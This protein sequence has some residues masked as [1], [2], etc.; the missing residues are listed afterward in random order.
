MKKFFL[1]LFFFKIVDVKGQQYNRFVMIADSLMKL[2]Q[3]SQAAENYVKAFHSNGGKASP[4]DRYN[5]AVTFGHLKN[6]DTVIF[7][8]NRL[9]T[10]I[11]FYD[12]ERLENENAFLFLKKNPAW[13]AV[14]ERVRKNGAKL[15]RPLMKELEEIHDEDQRARKNGYSNETKNVD[16]INLT[17]ITAIIDKYGWLGKDIVGEKGNSALFLVIQHSNV[18]T[19]E[20]YLPLVREAVKNGNAQ[21]TQLALMEDR[22]LMWRGKKQIYGS[23]VRGITRENGDSNWYVHPIEN[24]RE[25]DQR[26]AAIGLPPIAEYV[27]SFGVV[28]DL[29]AHI[30]QQEE[31]KD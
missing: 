14:C 11:N 9:A 24:P 18:E 17:K 22:A 5:A 20:K 29:E 19:L 6:A 27:K 23:Q 31:S 1:L 30:K 7:Y 4:D 25:V 16:A 3:Y 15:N 12:I 26:R 10:R 13:T 2:E 28:W 8:I 21:G